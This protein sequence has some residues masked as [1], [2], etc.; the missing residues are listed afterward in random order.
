MPL[1]SNKSFSNAPAGGSRWGGI[2]SAAPKTPQ[3]NIGHEYVVELV[4]PGYQETRNQGKGTESFKVHL[5]VVESDDPHL[6]VGSSAIVI[7]MKHGKAL[8]TAMSKMKATSVA[9]AGCAD[10]AEYDAR[11]P[12]GLLIS[13]TFNN[14]GENLIGEKAHVKVLQ[15]DQING[16]PGQFWREMEWSA[17]ETA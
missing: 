13:N 1:Q 12:G 10:D 5:R 7:Y 9:F 17:L 14:V 2:P 4:A 6:P 3:L 11:D 8:E 15:G 16:Q